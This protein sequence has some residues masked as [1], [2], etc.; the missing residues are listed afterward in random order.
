MI[1]QIAVVAF[2][3]LCFSY[4]AEAKDQDCKKLADQAYS[5]MLD[6]QLT[7]K[8]EIEEIKNTKRVINFFDKK[9]EAFNYA[10][11]IFDKCDK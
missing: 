4:D 10:Y 9:Y 8:S 5:L 6:Y 2:L 1:K 7:G 3:F 11:S